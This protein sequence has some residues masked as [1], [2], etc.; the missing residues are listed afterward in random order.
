M[1]AVDSQTVEAIRS[2]RLRLREIDLP[3]IYGSEGERK[4]CPLR[5][6]K[7]AVLVARVPYREHLAR[8]QR[9]PSRARAVLALIDACSARR[10]SVT[11][12]PVEVTREGERWHVRFVLGEHPSEEPLFLSRS[13]DYTTVR[14]ELDAGEVVLPSSKDMAKAQQKAREKREIPT[15]NGAAALRLAHRKLALRRHAM[16]VQQRRQ[17]SR[18]GKAI[19]KLH[20]ELTLDSGGI[21][22]LSGPQ[23]P[24]AAAADGDTASKG[25]DSAHPDDRRE[26]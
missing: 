11:V 8:A 12:T 21:F 24:E 17:L 20:S 25:P 16:T 7:P 6:G 19:E 26:A 13:R 18:V 1:I 4:K 2:A 14:D 10:L 5:E 9:E 15:A 23:H 22:D 3:V